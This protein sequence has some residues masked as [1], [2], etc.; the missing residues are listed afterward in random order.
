[1]RCSYPCL[2]ALALIVA[3][4]ATEELVFAVEEDTEL[5]R[6]VETSI[7]LELDEMSMTFG[8]EE[9]PPD[10]FEGL[11]ETIAY[12]E[13]LVVRDR[14]G[15]PGDGRPQSLVRTYEELGGVQTFE[16]AEQE[17]ERPQSSE[18]EGLAVRFTWDE[19]E[20]VYERSFEDDEGDDELLEPLLEDMD[21]RAFLPEDDVDEGDS[22]ELAPEVFRN[23]NRPGG[24]D[25]VDESGERNSEMDEQ[26]DENL[27]GT[28]EATFAGV[29]E[30]DGVRIGVL[31]IS[32][33]VATQGEEELET[34][35]G[36]TVLRTAEL[37]YELE[38]ELWWDLDGGSLLSF[39]LDGDVGMTSTN[40]AEVDLGG[41]AMEMVEVRVFSGSL[42]FRVGVERE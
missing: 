1:M 26:M 33:D 4:P 27:D 13:T 25:L 38:G 8:G 14:F 20:Q 17:A 12:E 10:H 6:T 7:S 28:I 36:A 2:T 23:V 9:V 24:V 32:I 5:V 15:P 40:E 16:T 21:M 11:E 18:L 30:E 22:W 29:R 41:G 34:D 19:D 3:T 35:D 31:E 37:S 42:S 39:E